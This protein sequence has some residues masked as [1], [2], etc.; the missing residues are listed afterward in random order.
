MFPSLQRTFARAVLALAA[1]ASLGATL[2][3]QRTSDA[4][5]RAYLSSGVVRLGDRV[6]LIVSVE[7][8]R[9]SEIPALPQVQGLALGPLPAPSEH[10]SISIFGNRRQE[11]VSRTWPIPLRPSE[12]GV[13][14]IPPFDVVVD[15]QKRATPELTLN[16]VRD[17]KGEDLG[18]LEIRPSSKKVIVGQPFSIELT[19]GFDAAIVDRTN[20]GNL[21][22]SWWGNLPGLL[23][24]ELPKA[25]GSRTQIAI[26]DRETV[27]VE[28]LERRKLRGREF[29]ALRLA[30]SFT[31]TRTGTL[32]IPTSYFEF[33]QVIERRDFFRTNREKG[34]T[35]FAPAAEL[36]IEVVPLPEAGRPV[37]YS[38]AIGKL[39]VRADATPRDVDAGES[40]KFEVQWSGEGNLEFF[41][42]PDPARLESFRDFRVYGRT[43]DKAFDRR[44]VVYD[45][46]PVTSGARE[47]PPLP[48][49]V[50]D[51]EAERYTVVKTEAIPI[52]VRALEGAGGLAAL[53]EAE[54]FQQDVRD[55]VRD[56]G[57][58]RADEPLGAGVVLG[59]LGAL[60]AA[61]IA[62]RTAVRRR[63]DP[64]SPRERA[65]RGARKQLAR[66]LAA[67]KDSRAQLDG[68]L[69]FVAART[70][71]RPEAWIGRRLGENVAKGDAERLRGFDEAV[72]DLEA[73][74]WGG[75]RSSVSK[76]RLLKAADDAVRGGL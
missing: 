3:A 59:V 5:V 2:F 18:F 17:M 9:T 45:L 34:E 11:T 69:G 29:V 35:F 73:C 26:N 14:S 48:L 42:P 54:R 39:A 71:E 57:P 67:A 28:P 13:Y 62:L 15:G 38:G 22:L 33:G 53:D 65:R 47:I 66:A 27:E 1:L 60:P 6:T 44:T 21:A 4:E 40:I 41:T 23:E 7:N 12:V 61:W 16:V 37:D 51:P 10:R 49:T 36:A 68:M 8:A 74:V 76:E 75:G 32:T 24:N 20:Y 43:E 30:R 25:S 58:R 63:Y 19:F 70:G 55:V 46:A 52:R 50:Y 72:R 56:V 31:P 64:N